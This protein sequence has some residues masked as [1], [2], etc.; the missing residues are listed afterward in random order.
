MD[1][2]PKRRHR[3][4]ERIPFHAEILINDSITAKSIDINEGGLYVSTGHP[5]TAGSVIEVSLPLKNEKLKI[6][7]R[8][9]H[10]QAAVGMGLMFI[11]LDAPQ[12][13]KIKEFVESLKKKPV[14]LKTQKSKV[15]LVD[16]DIMSLRI[17]RAKLILEGFQVFE[18]KDGTEAIGILN[19]QPIDL[20]VLDPCMEKMDGFKVLSAIKESKDIPVIVYSSKGTQDI[21]NKAANAGAHKFLL[22]A[23]TPPAKLSE[24]I[25][26]VI[27]NYEEQKK[28]PGR[29]KP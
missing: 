13:T 7:A 21:I 3:I 28:S 15:L 2:T 27:K 18:A 25:R 22:K 19:E 16:D 24:I 17:T 5:F 26:T 11:D 29:N 1:D 8:V 20:V 9:K 4:H 6:K 23:M 14:E 12:K 10:T